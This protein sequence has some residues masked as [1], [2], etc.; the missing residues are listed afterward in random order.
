MFLRGLN[1]LAFMRGSWNRELDAS[2]GFDAA[3]LRCPC[4]HAGE[5][6]LWPTRTFDPKS[7]PYNAFGR[8]IGPG[9]TCRFMQ[10]NEAF[11]RGSVRFCLHTPGA[12]R[13][14]LGGP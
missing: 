9:R 8:W 2:R 5:F 4:I 6:P 13:R 14:S 1:A 10:N 3:G 11:M 12:M 7:V